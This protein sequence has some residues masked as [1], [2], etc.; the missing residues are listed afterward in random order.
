MNNNE[1]RIRIYEISFRKDVL[2][3]PKTIKDLCETT[4]ILV[5]KNMK[6]FK[7]KQVKYIKYVYIQNK[8]YNNAY[9]LFHC[10]DHN[11]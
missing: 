1:M 11:R 6:C 3:T 10:F 2:F 8:Q 4:S 9:Y 5:R 7:I